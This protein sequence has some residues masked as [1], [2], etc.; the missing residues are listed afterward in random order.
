MKVLCI[1]DLISSKN[2]P[3]SIIDWANN[4]E[5]EITVGKTY[6]VFAISKYFDVLFYYIISDESSEYPLAYPHYLFEVYDENISIF[7]DTSYLKTKSI[8]TLEI[9]NGEIISFKEWT[10]KGERFYENLLE[11]NSEELRIFKKY[12]DDMLRE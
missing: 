6:T 11:G 2:S 9:K 4:S 7:W 1:A 12:R 8:D 5:L 3:Q 10:V